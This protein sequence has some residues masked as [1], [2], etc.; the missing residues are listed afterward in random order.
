MVKADEKLRREEGQ[1][2]IAE[3]VYETEEAE[4]VAEE[5]ADARVVNGGS[6]A[7][8]SGILP[9]GA[10]KVVE[11]KNEDEAEHKERSGSESEAD[12]QVA[13]AEATA[14]TEERQQSREERLVDD[15]GSQDGDSLSSEQ[16]L[17]PAHMEPGCHLLK[18]AG[19]ETQWLCECFCAV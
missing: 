5:R 9:N 15:G 12:T 7:Q 6:N 3:R 19:G 10:E 17:V 13:V 18:D 4:R 1:A 8:S 14:T 16:P 2:A 11:E